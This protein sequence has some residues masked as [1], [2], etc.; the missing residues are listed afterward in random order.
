MERLKRKESSRET[1]FLPIHELAE[2]NPQAAVYNRVSYQDMEN[3][4]DPILFDPIQVAKVQVGTGSEPKVMSAIVDGHTKLKFALDYGEK[5]GLEKLEVY[6]STEALM[7]NSRIVPEEERE[8]QDVLTITQYL[9]AVIE[10]TKVHRD[11]APRR[12]AAHFINGWEAMVEGKLSEKVSATAALSLLSDPRISTASERLL[13]RSLL[14]QDELLVDET[15]EERR[16]LEVA[17][18]Q[19]N[20]ILRD[21]DLRPTDVHRQ[22]FLLIARADPVI[23]GEKKTHTELYGLLNL[24]AVADKIEKAHPNNIVAQKQTLD[25]LQLTVQDVLVR[26]DEQSIRLEPS[27]VTEVTLDPTLTL[28]ETVEILESQQVEEQYRLVQ[29]K[30]RP[31]SFF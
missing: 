27:I 18:L 31:K 29:R 4:F 13:Q 20:T 2:A 17:L 12:I 21:A 8:A 25:S 6:D 19:M 11:I 10:P 23:G 1:F 5:Y 24:P 14:E 26:I 15:P 28:K 3:A 22:A 30:A 16:A 7:R 9:R